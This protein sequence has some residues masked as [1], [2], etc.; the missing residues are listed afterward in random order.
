MIQR[1]YK[2]FLTKLYVFITHYAA[3]GG[4]VMKSVAV[5]NT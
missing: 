3:D 2:Q 4:R 1:G 5:T